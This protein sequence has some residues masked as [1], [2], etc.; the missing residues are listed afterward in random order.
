M[1]TTVNGLVS[2]MQALQQAYMDAQAKAYDSINSQIGLFDTLDGSAKTSIDNLIQTLPGQVEYMNTYAEN[3]NKAMEL[4]VDQGLVQKLSDGSEE[5]A[6]I[7]AAI[8]EG[9]AEEIANLNAEFAKVEEG[10]QNFSTTVAEM[11]TDFSNKMSD[12]EARLEK[13]VEELDVSIEA[14]AAG[15]ATIQGYIDGAESMRSTLTATY[16]SLAQA[17]NAA[18][19]AALDIKSPSRVFWEDGRNTIRGAIGGAEEERP[20]LEQTYEAA[21]R[22]AIEAFERS[23]PASNVEPSATARQDAQT[24]AI[25]KAIS[26]KSKMGGDIIV[27]NYSPEALD[28]KTSAREFKKAQRDLSLGV[29]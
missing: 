25:V 9:G 19:K 8:V 1:Q 20:R 13:A 5:S 26:S 14:G 23:L 11:E 10:K 4:G 3:I 7:L 15:V 12:I 27:N 21:A 6:Q 16:R 29:S 24:A 28:E 22:A 17:A 18:Y 2:E